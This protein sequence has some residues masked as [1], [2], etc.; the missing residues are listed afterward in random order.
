[1]S[2]FPLYINMIYRLTVSAK[3]ALGGRSSEEPEVSLVIA[4]TLC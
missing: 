3:G 4:K 2:C 1:M